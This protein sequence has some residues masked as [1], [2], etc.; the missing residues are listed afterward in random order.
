MVTT[1]LS[2]HYSVPFFPT[3]HH[4][5]KTIWA[6]PLTNCHLNS[7]IHRYKQTD[8]QIIGKLLSFVFQS[9]MIWSRFLTEIDFEMIEKS[10]EVDSTIVK[11]IDD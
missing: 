1:S 2:I 11:M 8:W 10:L 4:Q 7:L 3:Y 9:N 5:L 6:R